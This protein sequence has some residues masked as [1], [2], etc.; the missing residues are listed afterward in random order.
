MIKH[1]TLLAILLLLAAAGCSP[2]VAGGRPPGACQGAAATGCTDANEPGH[3]MSGS[4]GGAGGMGHGM[5]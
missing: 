5:M 2:T 4:G 1:G 3:G